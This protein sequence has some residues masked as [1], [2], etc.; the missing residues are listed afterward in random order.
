MNK[1]KLYTLQEAALQLRYCDRSVRQFLKEGKL[2]GL[3]VLG[4]RKW[5]IPEDAIE[6]FLKG[7]PYRP[8]LGPLVDGYIIMDSMPCELYEWLIVNAYKACP[9]GDGSMVFIRVLR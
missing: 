5:L 7:K 6:E 1:K 3:K 8:Y 9:L 4:G 2:K